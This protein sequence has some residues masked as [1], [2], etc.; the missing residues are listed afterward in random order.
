VFGLA[1]MDGAIADRASAR[2]QHL[3]PGHQ[4]LW[5][6]PAAIADGIDDDGA[7]YGYVGG[8]LDDL[9]AFAALQLRSGTPSGSTLLSRD[10]IAAM[11]R[12]GTL[13]PSGR[14]TDYGLG[15]RLGGLGP[16]LGHSV[17]NTGGTSG[18]SAM[19]FVLPQRHLALVVEQNLYGILQGQAIMQVG[20]GA[21]RLLTG[22]QPP[23][24]AS[25]TSYLLVIWTTSAIALSFLLAAARAASRLRRPM[26]GR[27][28]RR[29]IVASPLSGLT[30]L[31]PGVVLALVAPHGPGFARWSPGYPTSSSPPRRPRPPAS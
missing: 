29:R 4:P 15:L 31:V 3:A 30:G 8:S 28:P 19:L 17:W 9:A 2:A 27:S 16:S 5:G 18:Y 12:P 1:G 20:F 24:P 25:D 10:S 21:V 26:A 13:R 6:H 7:G 11:R 22:Q 23:E 14:R